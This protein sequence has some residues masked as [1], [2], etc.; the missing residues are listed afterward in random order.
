[1]SSLHHAGAWMSVSGDRLAPLF[2]HALLYV[3]W[4]RLQAH[5]ELVPINVLRM[6]ESY[7]SGYHESITENVFFVCLL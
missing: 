4:R 7:I 1:M 5:C 6:D 2:L 3:A